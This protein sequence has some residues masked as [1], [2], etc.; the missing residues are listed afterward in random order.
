MNIQINVLIPRLQSDYCNE[1]FKHCIFDLENA[2]VKSWNF[3]SHTP[4]DKSCAVCSE[5]EYGVV[6]MFFTQGKSIIL[7]TQSARLGGSRLRC[8]NVAF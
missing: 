6:V 5:F 8:V 4:C 7:N 1:S 2:N 3:S